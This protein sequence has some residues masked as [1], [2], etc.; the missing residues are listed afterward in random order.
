LALRDWI[1]ILNVFLK[2]IEIEKNCVLLYLLGGS[3]YYR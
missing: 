3:Y 2:T 1:F